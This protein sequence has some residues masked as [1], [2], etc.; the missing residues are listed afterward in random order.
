MAL[1][2]LKLRENGPKDRLTFTILGKTG[3]R[4]VEALAHLVSS[5]PSLKSLR[6]EVR[7]SI[8]EIDPCDHLPGATESLDQ[9]VGQ[10]LEISSHDKEIAAQARQMEESQRI[11]VVRKFTDGE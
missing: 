5:N 1:Q 8:L 7:S 2:H 9:L 4:F 10:A 11:D 6:P 3:A